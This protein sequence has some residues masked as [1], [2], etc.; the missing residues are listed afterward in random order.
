MNHRISKESQIKRYL[1]RN[2][3]LLAD[4]LPKIESLP[5]LTKRNVAIPEAVVRV[6]VGQMLSTRAAETIYCRL[7]QSAIDLSCSTWELPFY[8]LREAGLSQAKCRTIVEFATAFSQEP[9]RFERWA[10]MEA[11][12]LMADIMKFWGMSKWTASI[13]AIF[14]FGHEDVY[15]VGDGSL[16][17]AVEILCRNHNADPSFF[18]PSLASPYRSY[19]ALYFWRGLDTGLISKPSVA[20]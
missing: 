2:I 11:T 20:S 9:A 3:P 1:C 17:R 16:V 6:V 14:H 19:L 12:A 10:N 18:D 7:S 5:V 4:V 15:P 8:A 13:L